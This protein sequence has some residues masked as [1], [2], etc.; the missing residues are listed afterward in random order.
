MKYKIA[1]FILTFFCLITATDVIKAHSASDVKFKYYDYYQEKTVSYSGTVPKYYCDGKLIDTSKTPAI[2]S[3]GVAYASAADIFASEQVGAT[4]KYKE[5]SNKLVFKYKGNTLVLFP[6]TKKAVLNGEDV[7]CS[8]LSYKIKYK[9]TKKTTFYVPTRFVA[10]SLG[11]LY[12]YSDNAAHMTSPVHLKYNDEELY[13]TGSIGSISYLDTNIDVSKSPSFVFSD[14]AVLNVKKIAAQTDL[15]YKYTPSTGRIRVK[16]K[17]ITIDYYLDSTYVYVNGL[18]K[19]CPVPPMRIYNYDLKCW[20]IYLPGRFTFETL[21]FDYSWNSSKKMSVITSKDTT[22]QYCADFEVIAIYDEEPPVT[23][24]PEESIISDDYESEVPRAQDETPS[25]EDE[26]STESEVPRVQDETPSL[27]DEELTESDVISDTPEDSE[28]ALLKRINYHQYLE[29]PTPDDIDTGE[30]K[31]ADDYYNNLVS[32]DI[33]GDHREFYTNNPLLNT[34]EAIKQMQILYYPEKEL[35]RIK[36]YTRTD[37][38]GILL[39]HCDEICQS[40]IKM[41]FDRPRYFYDRIIVLDAGHGGSQPGAIY[42]GVNEKDVNYNII[43]K[44][45]KKYFDDSPVKVFYTRSSDATVELM[46]RADLANRVQADM[47]ISVHH[48]ANNN[49]SVCGSSIY[50]STLN[51]TPGYKGLTSNALAEHL[52]TNVVSKMKTQNRGVLT[53]NFWVIRYNTVPAVLLELAFMSN[54][55][56]L[57]KIKTA[58][59]QK[60]AAKCIYNTVMEIYG[61]K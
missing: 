24:L 61:I 10:E 56:E 41:T 60:K 46:P 53:Q 6:G 33:P 36:I 57:A 58:D 14:N 2:I 39:V 49:T 28:L 16:Y 32:L 25:L 8:Y 40:C 15:S 54:K 45:C 47:F 26:E 5:S 4:C 13:Y 52:L 20:N 27:E 31:F 44:Y 30:L 55:S 1:I 38:T 51:N 21:G 9:S 12:D 17:E 34:G 19:I 29:I 37:A 23:Y 18:L 3:A 11:M 42:G 50:Y 43:C 7:P 22:G 59:F 48:N 35:T